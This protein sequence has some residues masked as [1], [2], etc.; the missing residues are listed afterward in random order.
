[1]FYSAEETT[2]LPL[3]LQTA[4][5]TL[6]RSARRI[7]RDE[8]AVELV[9][10]RGSDS[11]VAAY[12]DF[13]GPKRRARADPRNRIY[14][15]RN[16]AWFSRSGDPSSLRIAKGF[17]PDF[18][19]GILETSH[20]KS[21]LYGGRLRRFR[22]LSRNRRI[23]YLFFAGRRHVW[24]A[25]PQATTIELT[26]YGVRSID[27]RA[28]KDF[29]IPGYEYHYW[30]DSEDPPVFISQIPR[31]FAGAP[32]AADP[33]RADASGWLDRLPVIRAFRREV[34]GASS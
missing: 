4:L 34:L 1:M 6:N 2:D 29:S 3:E 20:S 27:V 10:R 9:L 12:Q 8:R 13:T 14:G 7:R 16:V 18:R 30:D 31:G 26:S 21:R 33:S 15:G 19:K 32:S 24:F 5:E 11:R 28:D 17:E 25:P 22:I 23:Q